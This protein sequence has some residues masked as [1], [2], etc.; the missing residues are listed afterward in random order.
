V[1]FQDLLAGETHE[2]GIG[3]DRLMVEKISG[4]R[5][6]FHQM[7]VADRADHD[8]ENIRGMGVHFEKPPVTAPGDVFV[9]TIKKSLSRSERLMKSR[10]RPRESLRAPGTFLSRGPISSPARGIV[11][12]RDSNEDFHK[13]SEKFIS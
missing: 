2:H 3:L 7:V 6:I 1:G 13:G 11:E 9:Q 5:Q 8:I 10:N 12:V 4:H